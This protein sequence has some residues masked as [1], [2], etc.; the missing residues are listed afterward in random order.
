ME[1]KEK[2]EEKEKNK[3]IRTVKIVVNPQ[4]FYLPVPSSIFSPQD[5]CILSYEKQNTW[6]IEKVGSDDLDRTLYGIPCTVISNA[7]RTFLKIEKEI[8]ED[9]NF[10]VTDIKLYITK[11]VD[12]KTLLVKAVSF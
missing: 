8:A 6:K 2:E 4:S 7:G 11:I 10:Y 1:Q 12:R 3:K 5:I 9:V